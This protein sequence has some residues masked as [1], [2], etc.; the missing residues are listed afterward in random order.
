MMVGP[1]GE[2]ALRVVGLLEGTAGQHCRV[3]GS[4][5]GAAGQYCRILTGSDAHLPHSLL[6]PATLALLVPAK[7]TFLSHSPCTE[8]VF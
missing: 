6:S 4:L 2:A 8:L 1:P 3:V 7:H 5:E